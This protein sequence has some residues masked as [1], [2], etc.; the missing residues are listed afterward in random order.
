[1]HPING[2]L[3]FIGI[4]IMKIPKIPVTKII[5]FKKD[6]SFFKENENGFSVFEEFHDDSGSHPIN[7]M[8]YECEFTSSHL[9]R[10]SP[11]NILDI[12][13]YR[14]FLIGLLASFKITTVDIRQRMASLQNE[15]LT[16]CD[17][18]K[19]PFPDNIFDVVIS[20]C[21]IEHF[22]LG[23]YGDEIDPD[24][25]KKAVSEMIRVLKPHGRLIISTTLTGGKPAIVFNAHRIYNYSNI[26][27]MLGEMQCEYEEFYS[28]KLDRPCNLNEITNIPRIWDVYLGCWMKPG[29]EK[30]SHKRNDY[31]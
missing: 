9:N 20:L 11:Q 25:D 6:I 15:I 13:S 31:D 16:I 26:L 5:D 24:G 30:N 27:E 22:G 28:T 4:E 7:Y 1:M 23:R 10:L 8:S 29:I 2:V 18:K 14:L 12:G 21:S 3:Q 19:L 17:A